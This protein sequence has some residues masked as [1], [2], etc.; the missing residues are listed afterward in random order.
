MGEGGM[1]R[2]VMVFWCAFLGEGGRG[3]DWWRRRACC[4][5]ALEGEAAAWRVREKGRRALC[6]RGCVWV[7]VCEKK[8]TERRFFSIPGGHTAAR[9]GAERKPRRPLSPRVALCLPHPPPPT[10]AAR[11]A[12]P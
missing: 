5:L 9:D 6:G 11:R 3:Q 12:C 10:S 1:E 4:L 2:E 8:E 7:C